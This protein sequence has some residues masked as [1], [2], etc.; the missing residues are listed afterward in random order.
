MIFSCLKYRHE[1]ILSSYTM[2]T[3]CA[4]V[5]SVYLYMNLFN[6]KPITTHAAAAAV[7]VTG[8]LLIGLD[9]YN[10]VRVTSFLLLLNMKNYFFLCKLLGQFPCSF[11]IGEA[12]L[13]I[14]GSVVFTFATI[15]NCVL[16]D[17]DSSTVFCQVRLFVYISCPRLIFLLLLCRFFSLALEYFFWGPT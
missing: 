16:D 7:A 15:S 9:L 14:E 3:V 13:V 17:T 2:A 8:C 10:V 11:S 5:S 6:K 12:I 4:A 1:E